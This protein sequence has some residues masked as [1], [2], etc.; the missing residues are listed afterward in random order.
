MASAG[1]GIEIVSSSSDTPTPY[2]APQPKGRLNKLSRSS[3]RGGSNPPT[4]LGANGDSF[5]TSLE[6]SS[7]RS[8]E[9]RGEKKSDGMP[10]LK[11]GTGGGGGGGGMALFADAGYGGGAYPG[12]RFGTG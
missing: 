12:E 9:V 10:V 11:L 3:G 5:L 7:M 1:G 4:E 2:P 6:V 8:L